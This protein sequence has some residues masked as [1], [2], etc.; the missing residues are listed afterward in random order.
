M[1]AS[2]D[3][4]ED[5]F[6]YALLLKPDSEYENVIRS[7]TAEPKAQASRRRGRFWGGAAKRRN[8][9]AAGPAPDAAFWPGQVVNIDMSGRKTK[10]AASAAPPGDPAAAA[11]AA[12]A[13]TPPAA[14]A[15]DIAQ[16]SESS[17]DEASPQAAACPVKAD[18]YRRFVALLEEGVPMRRHQPGRVAE[19]QVL[20]TDDSL[21]SVAWRPLADGGNCCCCAPK[22]SCLCWGARRSVPTQCITRVQRGT[23]ADDGYVICG[24]CCCCCCRCSTR[25]CPP[26]PPLSSSFPSSSS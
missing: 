25:Y 6:D 19:L 2:N 21:D 22:K 7:A 10:P 12:P 17:D 14:T 20:H 1:R 8:S 13:P 16:P 18:E 5:N 15:I 26:H 4:N 24:R 3:G 11:A 9:A 23:E